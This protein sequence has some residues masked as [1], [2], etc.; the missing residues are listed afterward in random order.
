MTN[1]Q[2][3]EAAKKLV[4]FAKSEHFDVMHQFLLDHTDEMTN[5]ARDLR[6]TAEERLRMLNNAEGVAEVLV[7]LEDS[8][9]IAEDLLRK[10][11]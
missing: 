4:A 11:E 3:I 1:E 2:K 10:A 6:G 8:I 7:R 5:T 9:A